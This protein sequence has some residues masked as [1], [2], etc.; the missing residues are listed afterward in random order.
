MS[1]APAEVVRPALVEETDAD[2]GYTNLGGV[3]DTL[4]QG[5]ILAR[6]I[7]NI[8]PFDNRVAV[9]TYQGSELPGFLA[10]GKHIDPARS[11]RVATTDFVVNN[12]AESAKLGSRG[13]PTRIMPSLLRD[14]LI[15]WVKKR[16]T[17][18]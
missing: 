14:L 13:K 16:G 5:T 11:Y 8:M 2:F 15:A 12:S 10:R 4:P 6:H 18:E 17:V 1:V 9:V 7:W 3:R